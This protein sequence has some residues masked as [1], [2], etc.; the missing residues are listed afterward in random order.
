MEDI[1]HFI[2][3]VQQKRLANQREL[4]RLDVEP[5]EHSKLMKELRD[6]RSKLCLFPV[7]INYSENRCSYMRKCPIV[8]R[9]ERA[10]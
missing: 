10:I 2:R 8:H 1:E 4:D 6:L 3:V 9:E 5:N 7:G